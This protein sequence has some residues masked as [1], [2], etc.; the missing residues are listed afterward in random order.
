MELSEVRRLLCRDGVGV[1]EAS[2]AFFFTYD[3]DGDLPQDRWL[4]FATIVTDDSS[5]SASDLS[6]PGGYRL[7]L[8]LTTSAYT[9]MFGPAPT[10]RDEHGVLR[11]GF[12]Y[13]VA[14]VVMPHPIYA[15]QHWVC[16]VNTSAA[17][18]ERLRPLIDD[19]Y[20]FAVRKHANQQARRNA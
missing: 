2:G 18:V 10:E 14:D 1:V 12:D 9:S 16:V 5:D 17:T 20:D 7:N 3:P 11:T 8:G 19:A 13:T 4:P 15:V 6:R